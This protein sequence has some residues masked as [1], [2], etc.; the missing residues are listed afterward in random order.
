RRR[1][2]AL[3][4][5]RAR[6]PRGAA[7]GRDGRPHALCPPER[8]HRPSHAG[9][10]EAKD[11]CERGGEGSGELPSVVLAADGGVLFPWPERRLSVDWPVFRLLFDG[12]QGMLKVGEQLRGIDVVSPGDLVPGL[13]APY[14]GGDLVDGSSG[15]LRQTVGE[16]QIS[17]AE[18]GLRA[19]PSQ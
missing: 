1:A 13:A 4:G 2:A 15:E 3:E 9:R 8:G 19:L 11:G 6:R 7:R 18:A 12:V 10:A 16:Q 14:L 5:R 17:P